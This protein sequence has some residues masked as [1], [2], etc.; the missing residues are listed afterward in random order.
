MG[1]L[2]TSRDMCKGSEMYENIVQWTVTIL[3]VTDNRGA[4]GTET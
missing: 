2:D 4:K 3:Q 1:A